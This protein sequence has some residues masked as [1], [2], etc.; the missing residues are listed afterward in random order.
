M[1][2]NKN[3]LPLVY[4]VTDYVNVPW[5]AKMLGLSRSTIYGLLLS[6][7]LRGYQ[8]RD[9]GWWRVRKDSVIEFAEALL[10]RE[11]DPASR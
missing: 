3:Q 11:E 4:R 8:V 9:G 2:D 5:A 10:R 7:T 6:G 1:K